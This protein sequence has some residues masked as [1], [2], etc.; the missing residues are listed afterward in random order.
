MPRSVRIWGGW[1]PWWA[2][3]VLRGGPGCCSTA[4]W[5][6]EEHPTHS[7]PCVPLLRES[8]KTHRAEAAGVGEDWGRWQKVA[9]R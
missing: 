7:C 4:L 6:L 5:A 3:G 1:C 8:P 9:G 2:W